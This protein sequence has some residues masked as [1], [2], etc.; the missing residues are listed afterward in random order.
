MTPT[1]ETSFR[2]A[3]ESETVIPIEFGLTSYRMG[4]YN[5]S[6][7]NEG[8]CLQLDLVDEVKATIEQK[9]AWYQNLMAKHYNSRIRKQRLLG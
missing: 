4:N 6:K 3:Y 8:I 1:G 7:N 5:D 9:L 2:L